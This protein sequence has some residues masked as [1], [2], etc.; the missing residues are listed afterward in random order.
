VPLCKEFER[1]ERAEA[2]VLRVAILYALLDRSN[3]IEAAHV[4]ASLALWRYC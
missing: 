2:H 3:V 4:K 1:R